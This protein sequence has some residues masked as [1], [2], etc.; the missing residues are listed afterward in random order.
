MSRLD[1]L[2]HPKTLTVTGRS[3]RDGYAN[4]PVYNDDVIRRL[5]D[6]LSPEGG[7]AVLRGSLAPDGAVIKHTAASPELL[8]HTGPAVVFED[9]DDMARRIDDDRLDVAPASVLVLRQAGPIGGPGMPEWGHLPVP[10]KLLRSGVRDLVRVSDARM[11]GTAYGTCVVHVT[12]E[13][14]AGGPLALVADG[15]LVTLNVG[16]RRLDLEVPA[17]ILARRRDHWRP[18]PPIY[19]RGWGK[20]YVSSVGQAD[21]GCDLDFLEAGG[22]TPEPAIH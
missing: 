10:A 22:P 15:D 18:P 12:P 8:A 21:K 4:A 17:E 14:A 19:R 13:S 1:P 6:P 20:L 5:D 9:Y 3:L 16:S 11:S 7:L 2:M